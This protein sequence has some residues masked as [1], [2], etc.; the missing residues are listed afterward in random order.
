MDVFPDETIFIKCDPDLVELFLMFYLF[1]KCRGKIPNTGAK[2]STMETFIG[3][4]TNLLTILTT[5]SNLRNWT[6]IQRSRKPFSK[7]TIQLVDCIQPQNL[8]VWK[9][10]FIPLWHKWF[11]N[12]CM[13]SATILPS[14][15]RA[16]AFETIF[17]HYAGRWKSDINGFIYCNTTPLT[18][19]LL[20]RTPPPLPPPLL[21]LPPPQIPL[22]GFAH[23]PFVALVVSQALTNIQRL[24]SS[25]ALTS[26]WVHE[27]LQ[28]DDIRITTSTTIQHAQS[29][30][31][32]AETLLHQAISLIQTMRHLPGSSP[33]NSQDPST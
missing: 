30:Q 33:E 7:F 3:D 17:T 4:I 24:S 28:Q 14:A 1:F 5:F 15:Q 8:P 11:T 27:H 6:L 31:R 16:Q 2:Q 21:S 26:A 20:F 9:I 22:S 32:D 25:I 19:P 29:I 23:R 13:G 18:L 12:H 10:R